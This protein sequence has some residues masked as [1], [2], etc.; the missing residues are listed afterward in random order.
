MDKDGTVAE[1][2]GVDTAGVD[3]GCELVSEGDCER[4]TKGIKRGVKGSAVA[5]RM[6]KKGTHHAGSGRR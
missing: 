5:T 3:D 2:D 6:I 4:A 1:E